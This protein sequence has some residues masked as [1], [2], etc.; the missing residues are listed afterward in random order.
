MTQWDDKQDLSLNELVKIATRFI[1]LWWR[2]RWLMAVV[3]VIGGGSAFLYAHI[4]KQ[5]QYTSRI[6][7][8]I[9]GGAPASGLTN[10]ASQIGLAN[11]S[12]NLF[13][14]DNVLILLRSK[15]ILEQALLNNYLNNP[16]SNLFNQY[17]VRTYPKDVKKKKKTALLISSNKRRA[18]FTRKE[19]STLAVI[20]RQINAQISTDRLEKKSNVIEL[21]VQGLDEAW[22][23]N[24][25]RILLQEFSKLQV[26]L[27]VG[28]LKS[29]IH[30][31]EN[32]LDSIQRALNASMYGVAQESD[33]SLGIIQSRSRVESRKKEMETQL[34]IGL[35]AEIYKGLEMTRYAMDRENPVIEI[36]D[37]PRFPL[38]KVG[39]GRVKF[40]VLG[41][42]LALA[43]ATS[44]VFL[45]FIGQEYLQYE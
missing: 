33:Q 42:M 34:L 44:Y 35:Y 11:N 3:T 43:L 39:K 14:N 38:D 45:K 4:T 24:F 6:T 1:K 36:L 32:R 18:D 21:K 28:T 16:D 23:L 19:D 7:F 12:S 30:A 22:T 8:V 37:N 27:K 9:E 15:R 5:I 26:Q 13:S 41:A 29:S 25:S 40:G 31:M 20:V 2:H 17:I 10:L